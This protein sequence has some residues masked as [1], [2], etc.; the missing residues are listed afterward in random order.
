VARRPHAGRRTTTRRTAWILGLCIAL[1]A[2]GGGGED[3]APTSGTASPGASSPGNA[4]PGTSAPLAAWSATETTCGIADFEAQS[5]AALNQLRR[6]GRSCGARGDYAAAPALT[7]HAALAQAAAGHTI[8]MAQNGYFDHTGLDGRTLGQRVT[9]AGYGWSA[10]AENI[11]RGQTDIAAALASWVASDGHC[12]NL[13]G[14]AYRHVALACT[15][16]AGGRRLWTLDL[17]AP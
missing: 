16:D 8:D 6:Q 15:R 17:A 4:S 12:A 9:D 10:V 2:C 1:S 11:A 5:L 14:A 13:M 7:W 3:A